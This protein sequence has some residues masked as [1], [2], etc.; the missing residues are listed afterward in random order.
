[1]A[2]FNAQEQINV[3]IFQDKLMSGYS[4]QNIDVSACY[5]I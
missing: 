4:L 3:Q 2:N 1:M 5:S